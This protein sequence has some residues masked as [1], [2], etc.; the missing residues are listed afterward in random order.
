M[1]SLKFAL[2]L[3]LA[4]IVSANIK[5]EDA[6]KKEE[7]WTG[8]LAEKA[9]DAKEGVV[10]TLKVGDKSVNLWAEGDVAKNLADWAKKG[11]KVDVHGTAVDADNVK[12]SKAEP[13][14]EK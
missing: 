3:M 4:L 12:V 1:K 8:T 11:A 5:A 2:P 13:H 9:K 10:A 14:K 6:P 7:S